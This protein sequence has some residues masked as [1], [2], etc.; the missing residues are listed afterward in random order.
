HLIFR[1]Q[2]CEVT[3]MKNFLLLIAALSIEG[4]MLQG[5]LARADILPT[6]D[7]I[8][9]HV[10]AWIG[11]YGGPSKENNG[12][13]MNLG[14]VMGTKAIAVIDSGYT[15]EMA[16]EMLVYIGKLSSLPIKYVI[17][18]N[19][20]PHRFFGNGVFQKQG[21]ETISTHEEA[22]RMK[23]L[24]AD[25]AARIET[26][27]ERPSGSIKPPPAPSTQLEAQKDL[28]LGGNIK[29]SLIP[30]G[31]NHTANSLI[32]VV[33]HDRVVFSGDILYGG[34][35]L[36]ITPDSDVRHWLQAY[37]NLKQ[38]VDYTFIP[39]HGKP[40]KLSAF[41]FPTYQYL[42][43]LYTHMSKAVENDQ[44]IDDAMASL[45]QS[46]F[47]K[48]ENFKDLAGRNSSWTYLQAEQQA[49]E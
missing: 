17:N 6:P 38:Y 4:V 43:T 15:P 20:Q 40:A 47:S 8:S 45:D 35:L 42:S 21:A 14:F 49:F 18:T 25:F 44:S 39:G 2:H 34:R 13:R 28:D 22:E 48:L 36:A 9:E 23:Q 31:A 12:F 41:D 5:T 33:P 24:S 26:V 1:N 7:Q 10:Y 3:T 16:K 30:S 11:P 46:A 32:V 19:S 29:I 37:Q 27:L